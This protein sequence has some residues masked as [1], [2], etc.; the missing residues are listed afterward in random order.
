MRVTAGIDIG[1]TGTKLGI[2]DEEGH[3]IVKQ[4]FDTSTYTDFEEFV[5][6]LARRIRTMIEGLKGK[7][8]FEGVGIGTPMGKYKDGT[9]DHASNLPW[10][11]LLPLAELMKK[12]V[13]A[14]VLVTNDANCAALG[15]K[16]FGGAK[17]YQ[18]FA[19]ITLGTGLGSG[20]LSAGR[21][22][23]GFDGFA[24]EMGHIKVG[25]LEGRTCGCGKKECLETY[26]S[27]TGIK[28]TVFSL[29]AK[30]HEGS[31]FRG[32]SFHDLSTKDIHE[33]AIK[34]DKIALKAFE[35]TGKILGEKLS[36]VV[37]LFNPEAIFFAGGLSLAGDYI[38]N[39]TREHMEA[40]LLDA[41]KGKVKFLSSEL[42]SEGAAILGA[43]SLIKANLGAN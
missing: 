29:L 7:F 3:I 8:H 22:V 41:Y 36:D 20:F 39:P 26:V 12:S 34:G 16:V 21:L 10:K 32:V 42:G 25:D 43:A 23:L 6:E 13:N 33:A 14:P 19:M 27:A 5:S 4:E 30:S 31:E 17:N 28:R 38:I 35:F 9:I 40:N 15:E 18:D 11:G 24:G 1:G 37:M 2:V